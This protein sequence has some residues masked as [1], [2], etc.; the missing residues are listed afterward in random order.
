MGS[1]PYC[2]QI[3]G[4]IPMI[5]CTLFIIIFIGCFADLNRFIVNVHQG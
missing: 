2:F 1:I 5:Q 4:G 3:G